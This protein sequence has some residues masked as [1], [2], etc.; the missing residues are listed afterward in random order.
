MRDE[1]K[2]EKKE[3]KSRKEEAKGEIEGTPPAREDFPL[4]APFYEEQFETD[5]T[6][7][8][9]PEEDWCWRE[10]DSYWLEEGMWPWPEPR[11]RRKEEWLPP[12]EVEPA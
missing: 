6:R 1:P 8:G 9:D 4:E 12:E 3:V 2:D 11:P 7:P 10:P 5:S